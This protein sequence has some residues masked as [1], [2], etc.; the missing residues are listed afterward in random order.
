MK[1]IVLLIVLFGTMLSACS[2]YREGRP[3]MVFVKDSYTWYCS[4]IDTERRIAYDC[5]AVGGGMSADELHLSDLDTWIT[6][7]ERH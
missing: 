2:D 6:G 3:V 7:Y 5:F 1:R 4:K